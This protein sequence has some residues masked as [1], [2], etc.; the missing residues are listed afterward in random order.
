MAACRPVARAVCLTARTALQHICDP[1]D[2]PHLM[3]KLDRYPIPEIR[4]PE[5][6]G[7]TLPDVGCNWGRWSVA[8]ARKGYAVVGIDPSMGGVMA[9]RRWPGSWG[10]PSGSSSAT[11][12]TCPSRRA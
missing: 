7:E 9:A 2:H 4:L 11:G 6:Q 12:A 1:N 3:G 10:S 5:S 8:A